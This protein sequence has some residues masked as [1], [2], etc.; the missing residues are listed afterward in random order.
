MNG[1]EHSVM[2]M[3][4]GNCAK[5]CYKYGDDA[6]HSVMHKEKGNGVENS[7]MHT[8][9]GNDA[10]HSVM[11]KEKGNG[12]EH[13]AM[14]KEKGNYAEHSVMQKIQEIDSRNLNK[15]NVILRKWLATINAD[16]IMVF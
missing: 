15:C 4:K 3:E 2:Y 6:K 14:H 16:N 11:H 1:A 5:Q 9:K 13:S 10:K 12:V 8:E 7:A